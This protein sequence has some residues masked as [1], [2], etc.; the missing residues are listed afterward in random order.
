MLNAQY[1]PLD[2][3]SVPA[4]KPGLGP[5]IHARFLAL[6]KLFFLDVAASCPDTIAIDHYPDF[7]GHAANA[8]IKGC[9]YCGQDN[10]EWT[11]P[12]GF[13]PNGAGHTHIGD[14]WTVAFARMLGPA[15]GG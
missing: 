1:A 13:H 12:L 15:Y 9:P 11:D 8:N 4:A 10:T 14:K 5:E 6:N 2:T 3:C 7:L